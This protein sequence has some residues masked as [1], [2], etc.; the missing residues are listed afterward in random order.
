MGRKGEAGNQITLAPKCQGIFEKV[1][2]FHIRGGSSRH[3]RQTRRKV[4]LS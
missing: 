1:Q 4:I 2:H 3:R